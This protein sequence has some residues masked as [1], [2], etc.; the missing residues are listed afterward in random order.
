MKL[1]ERIMA[2]E[3]DGCFIDDK[4]PRFKLNLLREVGGLEDRIAEL[5]ERL[6][7]SKADYFDLNSELQQCLDCCKRVGELEE[8]LGQ[9]Q[10]SVDF[11]EKEYLKDHEHWGECKFKLEVVRLKERIAEL[12]AELAAVSGEFKAAWNSAIEFKAERDKLLADRQ[13]WRSRMGLKVSDDTAEETFEAGRKLGKK[14][15]MERA[16]EIDEHNDRMSDGTYLLGMTTAEL[17]REEIDK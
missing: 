2:G 1:S 10:R 9:L 17:I 12:E 15:G 13:E 5:E 6:L 3:L 14:E 8:Q 4:T 7:R 11:Q 16:A